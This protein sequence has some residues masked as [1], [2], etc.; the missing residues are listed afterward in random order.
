L[1]SFVKS[2]GLEADDESVQ[3]EKFATYCVISNRFS[4]IVCV[5]PCCV[6]GLPR[7]LWEFKSFSEV[8]STA[9]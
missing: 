4:G 8:D 6:P 2:F 7:P 3:F 9:I 5:A 1:E